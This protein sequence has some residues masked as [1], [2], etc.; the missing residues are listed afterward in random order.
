MS[1][2]AIDSTVEL[3]RDP[4]R[5]ISRRARE[6]E[7][8][9][10]QTRLALRPVI[11]LT[12]IEGAKLFYDADRFW[13]RDALPEPVQA[14]LF[15]R[16]G[17]QTLDDASHLRR[18]RLFLDVLT[19]DAVA[20][21]GM[22]A[23][24]EWERATSW[25]HRVAVYE[26]AKQVYCRAVCTWAGVPLSDRD[27]AS[28]ASDL[29]LLFEGVATFGPRHWAARLARRRLERWL[30][31]LVRDVR[32]G[33][34]PADGTPL[35]VF[36]WHRDLEG[37]LLPPRVVA[38]DL[39]SVLRPTVAVSVFTVFCAL[40]L[41]RYPEWRERL[42]A[43]ES[44][45]LEP[46][47]Q[48]VRRFYP[49]APFVAARV[50]RDFTWQGAD[51]REGT[52]ALL[53]LFGIDHDPRI[54]TDPRTFRPERFRDLRDDPFGFVPQGGGDVATTHRCA[55]EPATVALM[56]G[57]VVFLAGRVAYAVPDQD[58]RIRWRGLPPVPR[59]GFLIEAM[60]A[61]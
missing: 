6:L 38:V 61:R 56:K 27:V 50:R 8:D 20:R 35:A 22:L 47:V 7:R 53:D 23:D 18:K 49:F 1:A 40:A 13:R 34:L 54:W 4:Y 58:L 43:P 28:T 21:L 16:G 15:G 55:G 39:L 9:A 10:F 52:L 57:A 33:R 14:T 17:V 41:H 48:E 46:F 11:C 12:G 25:G 44:P 51:A 2:V 24:R 45:D 31:G 26:L 3:L 30:A 36:A 60:R 19:E 37:R 59:G 29:A 5:F 32:A 42:A